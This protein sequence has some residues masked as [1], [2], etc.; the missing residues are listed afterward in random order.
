MNKKC[1]VPSCRNTSS[2][3]KTKVFVRVNNILK[4]QWCRKLNVDFEPKRRYYCCEDHLNLEEDLE[5]YLYWKL[6]KGR[7]KLK[8]TASL[9]L[10]GTGISIDASVETPEP[11]ENETSELRRLLLQEDVPT[12]RNKR[13]SSKIIPSQK[14]LIDDAVQCKVEPEE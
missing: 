9:S 10:A 11:S 6:M 5:N 7:P 3:S 14:N 4:R 2:N 1:F 12:K 8:S 13:D